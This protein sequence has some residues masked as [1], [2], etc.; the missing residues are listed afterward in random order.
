MYRLYNGLGILTVLSFALYLTSM[1]SSAS[2]EI[3]LSS[4]SIALTNK[5][6]TLAASLLCP[7]FEFEKE[8]VGGAVPVNIRGDIMDADGVTIEYPQIKLSDGNHLEVHVTLQ[9]FTK[10]KVL[11]KSARY[12]VTGKQPVVLRRIVMDNIDVHGRP[13]WTHG[14]RVGSANRYAAGTI[15]SMPFFTDGFFAGIE[16]PIAS[17]RVENGK[18]VLAHTPG[19]RLTSDEWYES[20]KAVYGIAE[21]GNEQRAFERYLISKSKPI[22][23]LHVNYNSWWTTLVPFTEAEVLKIADSFATNLHDKYNVDIDSFCIDLGWSNPQSIWEIDSKLFPDGFGKIRKAIKKTGSSLGLWISPSSA[24]P[25]ALDNQWAKKQGYEIFEAS[26]GAFY[27]CPAGPKYGSQFRSQ[28]GSLIKE[29]DINLIKT[30]GL[31]MW[32]NNPDHGHEVGGDQ[33]YEAVAQ[34]HIANFEAIHKANPRA[35]IEPFGLGYDPSPWWL[36]YTDEILA[37]QGDDAPPARVPCPVGRESST[38]VRD[39]FNL[40]GAALNPTPVRAHEVV[41]MLHQT[42]EDFMNDAVTV[43]MRGNLFFPMYVN[44]RYMNPKR[45]ENLAGLLKWARGNDKV[46]RETVPLLPASWQNGGVPRFTDA[47]IMPREPYG[48]AHFSRSKGFVHLRNPWIAA[49][50]YKI[51]LDQR[52]GVSDKAVGLSAVSLYPE[53]ELYGSNL[54]Y[55]DTLDV[56][57]A[58]YETLVLSFSS[59]QPLEDVPSVVTMKPSLKASV[60]E[61]RLDRVDFGG[62]PAITPDATSPVGD[63]P[64]YIRLRLSADIEVSSPKAALLILCDGDQDLVQPYGVADIDGKQIQMTPIP[65]GGI[66]SSTGLKPREFWSFLELPLKL[67]KYPV[68]LEILAGNDCKRISAWVLGSMPGVKASYPNALPQPESI[69]LGSICLLPVTDTST[70]APETVRLPRILERIDGVYLDALAPIS[71]KQGWGTLQKNRSV[72]EKPMR[73]GNQSFSRGLGTHAPSKIVYALDG[74]YSRFQAMAGADAAHFPTITMEVRADGKELWKSGFMT[75]DDGAK[76]VDLDVTGVQRL[77]LIVGDG[78][79]TLSGDHA[80]WADAKLLR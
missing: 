48:Y 51:T 56:N 21:P 79:N 59:S 40:Q 22:S 8:T 26:P 1:Q 19:L 52:I 80:D 37:C 25:P 45:W 53:V 7:M 77:E 3:N 69:S 42:D 10:E 32:C 4:N 55:G 54:K 23:K 76:K 66:W 16:F 34:G 61:S 62:E 68:S 30:D 18:I 67:G 65:S 70:I 28:L 64:S 44:P 39:Y 15:Q 6:Y 31:V 57:M 38:T 74:Q 27:A 73:I 11:R 2:S 71:V 63:A 41:G 29:Y 33:S 58:A 75:K 20:R 35:I 14:G 72:W 17:S 50:T 5:D 12:R 43:L 78:G 46:L 13:V 47:G 60:T 49:S 9:W 24:Y 36:L